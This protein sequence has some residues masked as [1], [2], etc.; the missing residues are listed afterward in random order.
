VRIFGWSADNSGCR[1]Y[2]LQLPFDQLAQR[3]H[4]VRVAAKFGV[5]DGKVA[6]SS[7]LAEEMHEWYAGL[8]VVVG[9]RV[10][11][12]G[13][14]G[15][16]QKMARS[17]SRPLMVYEIDDDLTSIDP[18]NRSAFEFYGQP[19][20]REAIWANAVV[21]DVVT[22]STDHLAEVFSKVNQNVIVLPNCVPGWLLHHEVPARTDGVVTVGWQGSATHDMDWADSGRQV[23]RYFRRTDRAELHLMGGVPDTAP[24]VG[25][26]T[27]WSDSID[28]Y[29]RSV[30]WHLALAP[31]KPHVFNRSKSDLRVKEASALG[32]P[33][34]A[35]DT[36]PYPGYVEHGRTGYLV[37]QPHEW[38]TYL[39][40]LVEDPD[41]R[42]AMGANAREQAAEWTVE[43]RAADW[44][45]AYSRQLTGAGVR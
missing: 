41:T 40:A 16:W 35:S 28:A 17:P 7:A 3:G 10:C 20:I 9:Q 11:M 4:D 24:R 2:R 29:Y 45:A 37:R 13:P 22:V 44:E 31:L 27:G 14:T 43:H 21:A 1:H 42:T 12:P 23:E 39:R 34:I 6:G 32:L 19:H 15:I 5:D 38:S 33:V 8:D 36:G 30:D 25:R 26:R 18:S